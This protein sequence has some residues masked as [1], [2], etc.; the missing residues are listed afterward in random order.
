MDILNDN[1]EYCKN[2]FADETKICYYVNSGYDLSEIRSE[3]Q[4]SLFTYDS[5]VHFE[6]WDIFNYLKETRRI[7]KNGGM[8]LFH[9]SNNTENYKVTF[10]T[11]TAGRNYMSKDLFAYLC[12]RAG[13]SV[14]Q[15]E[16]ID[17]GSP[18]L[19]CITLVRR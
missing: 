15:Q 5:M 14:I 1:I 16:V 12:N 8:A 11:G 6:M 7:L 13:L 9:H 10:A 17:W 19:D 3:S 18:Q 4:T 2:R